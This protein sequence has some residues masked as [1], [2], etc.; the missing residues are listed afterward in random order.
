MSEL[1]AVEARMCRTMQLQ[2]HEGLGIL[3]YLVRIGDENSGYAGTHSAAK[4][5]IRK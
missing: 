5:G 1:S 3:R 4:K 2:T